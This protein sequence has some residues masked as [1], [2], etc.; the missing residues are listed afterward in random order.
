MTLVALRWFTVLLILLVVARKSVRDDWPVLKPHLGYLVLLGTLGFTTFNALYYIAAHSTTALNIGIIQGVTPVFILVG[1]FLAYGT[2]I[3]LLQLLGVSTAVLGVALVASVGSW[4]S[5]LASEFNPGD[6]LIIIACM[7]Y[8]GYTVWL[9][10]RPA[11]SALGFFTV[12][13][14]AA[15]TT[16]LPLAFIEWLMGDFQAPTMFGWLLIFLIAVLPSL[17]GQIFFIKGVEMIGPGRAGIFV[18]LVPVIAA[19]FAVVFLEERF[20]WFHTA[21]LGLVLLG[22]YLSERGKDS[23]NPR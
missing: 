10:K 11:A 18:N 8:A 22:I 5:L 4:R 23:E 2:P 16:A 1:V 9:R 12:M 6:L 3:R 21:A 20:E 14:A 15:F 17:L 19:I 13:A 7:L